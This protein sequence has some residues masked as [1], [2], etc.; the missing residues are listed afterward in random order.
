MTP[1]RTAGNAAAKKLKSLRALVML[2]SQRALELTVTIYVVTLV[3][4]EYS[5]IENWAVP[6]SAV[7]VN[8]ASPSPSMIVSYVLV[9]EVVASAS[10][11]VPTAWRCAGPRSH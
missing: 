9:R 3:V 10:F 11:P 4:G 6:V 2:K 1:S 8:P 7:P 5:I